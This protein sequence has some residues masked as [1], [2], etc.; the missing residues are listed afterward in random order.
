M[1]TVNVHESPTLD[2]RHTG[3]AKDSVQVTFSHGNG[4]TA[5]DITSITSTIDV[6]ANDYL[7][8]C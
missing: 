4:G 7:R 6:S 2:I 5:L 8:F 1:G 3:T